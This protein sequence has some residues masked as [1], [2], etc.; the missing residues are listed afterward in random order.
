VVE[1]AYVTVLS[2]N[3]SNSAVKISGRMI[4][5]ISHIVCV[6]CTAPRGMMYRP[7]TD[8]IGSELQYSLL[9]SKC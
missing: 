8:R 7:S 2:W 9:C 5:N 3:V 6:M 4:T 1:Y